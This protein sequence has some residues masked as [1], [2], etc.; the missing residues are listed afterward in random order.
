MSNI[1]SQYYESKLARI[2]QLKKTNY[3]KMK[4]LMIKWE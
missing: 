3:E 4:F 2:L 1:S